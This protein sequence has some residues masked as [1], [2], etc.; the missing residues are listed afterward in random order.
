[1]ETQPVSVT[2]QPTKALDLLI[3]TCNP[4][5]EGKQNLAAIGDET[6]KLLSVMGED[7]LAKSAVSPNQLGDLL[8]LNPARRFIFCG[9][10][11]AP[12]HKGYPTLCFHSDSGGPAVVEP[13]TLCN[14]MEGIAKSGFLELIFLNGCKSLQL[15]EALSRIPGLKCI[16]CWETIVADEAAS[17]FS[18]AFF[19]AVQESI[20]QGDKPDYSAAF[21]LAASEVLC[22]TRPGTLTSGLNTAV[23]KWELREPVIKDGKD[24]S[25]P[26]AIHEG[27][28]YIP[29]PWAAGVPRLLMCQ[30]IG[31]KQCPIPR[32]EFSD[33]FLEHM[34]VRIHEDTVYPKPTAEPY[35]KAAPALVLFPDASEK[36]RLREADDVD[37]TPLPKDVGRVLL[38]T[39]SGSEFKQS[40]NSQMWG[41]TAV[42]NFCSPS[43]EIYSK[44]TTDFMK[45]YGWKHATDGEEVPMGCL[46]SNEQL[47][48]F[49]AAQ[50]KGVGPTPITQ[51]QLDNPKLTEIRTAM[52][53][54]QS[55]LE[56]TEHPWRVARSTTGRVI[57]CKLTRELVKGLLRK[58]GSSLANAGQRLYREESYE[59]QFE[60]DQADYVAIDVEGTSGAFKFKRNKEG[61][62]IVRTIN[63]LAFEH[64]YAQLK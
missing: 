12:I 5:P 43:V 56:R 34:L 49:L 14:A 38:K 51:I 32:Q 1:M 61:K 3:V 19:K 4:F 24:V 28:S 11:D 42:L 37:A 47:K 50:L 18:V 54:F 52:R 31:D 27:Q 44:G 62:P 21:D 10:A 30:L 45:L 2:R 17:I 48:A 25:K 23:P 53:N 57:A 36:K 6:K 63:E 8:R 39:K 64:T 60:F 58:L 41:E 22:Q 40:V 29:R 20:S 46:E 9:H 15:G 26:N 16:V 55:S 33:F 35:Q 59:P 13:T 7:A